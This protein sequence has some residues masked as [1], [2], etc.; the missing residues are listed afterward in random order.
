MNEPTRL[1]FSV[2]DLKFVQDL[3]ATRQA[4]RSTSVKVSGR[5]VTGAVASSTS[6]SR[7]KPAIAATVPSATAA[8]RASRKPQ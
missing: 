3:I 7:S 6:S 2:E 1:T 4:S 8:T 5:K